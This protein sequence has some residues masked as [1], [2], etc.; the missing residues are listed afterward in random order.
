VKTQQAGKALTGA[1]VICK[2]WRLVV[3]LYLVPDLSHLYNWSINPLKNPFPIYN[4]TPLNHDN[5]VSEV[6]GLETALDLNHYTTILQKW[7]N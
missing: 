4:H 6:V 2:L 1:V 7:N 5:L 3:M